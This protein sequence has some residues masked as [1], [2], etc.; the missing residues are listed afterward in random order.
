MLIKS[1][2]LRLKIDPLFPV[3]KYFLI[4]Y[5]TTFSLMGSGKIWGFP[6]R[7]NRAQNPP[8]LKKTLLVLYLLS[9]NLRGLL[10]WPY[11]NL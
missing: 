3:G 6:Q 2:I 7:V 9:P 5:L 8:Y 10:K 11:L 1:F 4:T